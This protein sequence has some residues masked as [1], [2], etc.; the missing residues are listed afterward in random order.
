MEERS[1][2]KEKMRAP[3]KLAFESERH[4][5]AI[6]GLKMTFSEDM[7]LFSKTFITAPAMREPVTRLRSCECWD[8]ES[9]GPVLA[10]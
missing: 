9:A 8:G 10:W 3:V 1:S 5:E 2:E 6:G 4:R 7:L